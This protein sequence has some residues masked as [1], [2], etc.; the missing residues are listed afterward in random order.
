MDV[1]AFLITLLV[2]SST[3]ALAAKL[4][5]HG[6]LPK[7]S[8]LTTV[9]QIT[10][11][12]QFSH[13]SWAMLVQKRNASAP[14]GFQTIL[15]INSQQY[16][17]P[18]S[19][20]KVLTTS[21]AITELGPDYRWHTPFIADVSNGSSLSV[22]PKLCIAGHVRFFGCGIV[23]NSAEIVIF[24]FSSWQGDPSMT[25]AQ[26]RDAV[27]SLRNQGVNSITELIVDD[28]IF[29]P[30]PDTWEIGD[31]AY[32]YGAKPSSLILDEGFVDF[33]ILPGQTV[34]SPAVVS[35]ANPCALYD[36]QATTVDA[37]L[38]ATVTVEVDI[39]VGH[40][41]VK[42]QI[43]LGH[44]GRN[45]RRALIDPNS[46]FQCTLLNTLQSQRTTMKPHVLENFSRFLS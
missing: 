26:L 46:F 33:V 40:F 39:G 12:P 5:S 41:V 32:Y 9:Q 45:N 19:N 35:G 2:I 3:G 23:L 43:P 10:S 29:P 18:A 15:D 31:F 20:N 6:C 1:K 28:T 11:L 44:K 16:M 8:L 25:T 17:Q 36:N 14:G 30:P 38:P 13:Q 7:E 22:I 24:C 4:S 37:D 42:G 27:T 34:G 21:A